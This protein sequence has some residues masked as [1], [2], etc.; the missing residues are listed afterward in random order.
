[1]ERL[2]GDVKADP[3]SFSAVV[4]GAGPIGLLGAMKLANGNWN[5]WVYSRGKADSP[6]V[7]ILSAIG[8]RFVSST[9]HSPADLAKMVGNI[10][11]V[12]EATGVA[13]VSLEVLSVLGVN[14]VFI[15]TGVP[16]V[17]APIEFDAEQI[18]RNLV[19]N[20]QVLCG[21]VNAGRASFEEG[22][23]DLVSFMRRFPDAVRALITDRVTLDDARDAVFSRGGIKSVIT[24]A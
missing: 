1:V 12:Y 13:K 23:Q 2:P 6:N 16:G 19:L 21:T 9:E 14:G 4:L 10:S 22:V 7:R 11:L 15:F 8:A 20:N 3:S 18:M 5:T 17:N 24:V